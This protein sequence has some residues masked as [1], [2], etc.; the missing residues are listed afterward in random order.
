[1]GIVGSFFSGYAISGKF[2]D[3]FS[4]MTNYLIK[5]GFGLILLASLIACL[6]VII[7]H[8]RRKKYSGIKTIRQYYMQ[9]STR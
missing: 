7:A 9:R 1:M 5:I 3:N 8:F 6:Y 2:S 4:L